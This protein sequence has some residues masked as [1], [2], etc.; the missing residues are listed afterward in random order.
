MQLKSFDGS[1][2]AI[3]WDEVDPDLAATLRAAHVQEIE[4]SV[5][6]V[7]RPLFLV[8]VTVKLNKDGRPAVYLVHAMGRFG[9][10]V[11]LRNDQIEGLGLEQQQYLMPVRANGIG[12]QVF[13]NQLGLASA[14]MFARI[15]KSDNFLSVPLS[16]RPISGPT[17]SWTYCHDLAKG[18]LL[19]CAAQLGAKLV[20]TYKLSAI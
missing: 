7:K 8:P 3:S 1:D 9:A 20:D 4:F 6:A 18:Y 5:D 16:V 19:E 11:R 14:T 10:V 15:G 17:S 12:Q 13:A 2:L